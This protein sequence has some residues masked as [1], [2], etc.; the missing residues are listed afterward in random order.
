[1]WAFEYG[2]APGTR[3]LKLTDVPCGNPLIPYVDQN[4]FYP[5]IYA[6]VGAPNPF[7]TQYATLQHSTTYYFVVTVPN[8][9]RVPMAV[10]M[11]I[12]PA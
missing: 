4:S 8:A 11:D 1:L 10:E 7:P 5:Q 2:S 12:E 3:G 6:V 9:S